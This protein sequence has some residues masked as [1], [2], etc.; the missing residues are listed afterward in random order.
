MSDSDSSAE[1][2]QP[3][4]RARFVPCVTW[5]PKGV[6]KAIP[7]KVRL[8]EEELRR[9]IQET[10]SRVR[11]LDVAE[12]NDDEEGEEDEVEAVNG[13]VSGAAEDEMD[14][15]ERYGFDTYDD[16]PDVG[17]DALD[18]GALASFPSSA[19]DPILVGDGMGE[20]DVDSEE[21][22][23]REDYEIKPEDNLLA[24]GRVDG[25]ASSIQVYVFNTEEGCLY[26]HHDIPLGFTPLA[27]EYTRV[28]ACGDASE[29]V[30]LLVVGGMSPCIE[31][32]DLDLVNALEP[33]GKLG[34]KKNKKKK[35]SAVGH[36]DSVLCLAVNRISRHVLASGSV[37]QQAILW[38]LNSG[39]PVS[40]LTDFSEKVQSL[41]WHPFEERTLATGCA[42]K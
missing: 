14:V 15:A 21:G 39:S 3:R 41:A 29:Q 22:S 20:G 8:S 37:D 2:E 11:S 42:D 4:N 16:E 25:D 27:V 6:A 26:V 35:L 34:R 28:D 36:R 30:N 31:L 19:E 24:V 33:V 5:I 12:E 18:L 7:D 32:W 38:D 10:E 23:D 13:T 1:E 40:K 17:A 9:I